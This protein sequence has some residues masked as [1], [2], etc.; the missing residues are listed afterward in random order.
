VATLLAVAFIGAT[1]LAPHRLMAAPGE[2]DGLTLHV[3]EVAQT[4]DLTRNGERFLTLTIEIGGTDPAHLRRVQPLREEFEV[5]AGKT[6]LP[7]RWLRGGSLPD[8][9]RHLRFTLGFSLPKGNVRTVRLKADLPRLEGDEPLIVR[10][11]KL[12][13]TSFP[14]EVRG[15]NWT[16]TVTEF[17][18]GEYQVPALPPQG[19][20]F[21]KGGPVDARIFRKESPSEPVPPR[22]V[23]LA[24]FSHDLQL[25][26]PTL[27][28]SGTLQSDTG[29]SSSLLA[30]LLKRDPS[31]TVKAPPYAPILL[32]NFYFRVPTRGRPSG[33]TLTFHRR[34]PQ[35][36]PEIIETPD[37]P[38]PGR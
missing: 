30:A 16:L 18:E 32:G 24:F 1:A 28:V 34:P 19:A 15:P 25:Y 4:V 38:L 26:D 23:R 17:T 2:A 11:D 37:L 9:P 27:D 22:A 7:C 13:G 8:D 31:R 6:S 21:S 29:E 33:V 12:A 5:L 35:P 14:R 20:F 36:K 10:L 3:V